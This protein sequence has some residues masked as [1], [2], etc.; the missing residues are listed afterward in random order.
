MGL[1]P[2]GSRASAGQAKK[3]HITLTALPRSM[4]DLFRTR[5]T[6]VIRD[7]T[8]TLE[9]WKN[10]SD[11][12]IWH[13]ASS[14]FA[15]DFQLEYESEL[16][17]VISKLVRSAPSSVQTAHICS[18]TADRLSDWRTNFAKTAMA[19]VEKLLVDMEI[20]ETGE[21]AAFVTWLLGDSYRFRPFYYRKCRQGE[22]IKASS[23]QCASLPLF[24]CS[25]GTGRPKA[26]SS[27]ISWR[28]S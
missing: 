16:F 26:S 18:Q 10:P 9:I 5:Y 14:V 11:A 12:D 13:F 23:F 7:F 2:R 28:A 24:I 4:V 20:N 1:A 15:F 21:R 6:P 19:A 3:D 17:T 22:E 27:P 25:A 8:G